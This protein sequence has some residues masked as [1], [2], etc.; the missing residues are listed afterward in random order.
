MFVL[1]PKVG[2]PDFSAWTSGD[3]EETAETQARNLKR[4]A[5]NSIYSPYASSFPVKRTPLKSYS[6]GK[7][8]YVIPTVTAD[9]LQVPTKSHPFSSFSFLLIGFSLLLSDGLSETVAVYQELTTKEGA[10]VQ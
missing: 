3:V 2:L 7:G 5:Y 1:P 8:V 4:K 10:P 6:T 9:V